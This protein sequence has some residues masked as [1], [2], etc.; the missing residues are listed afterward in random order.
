MPMRKS[1]LYALLIAVPPA[2]AT[3]S[4]A[5]LIGEDPLLGVVLGL[6]VGGILFSLML[7]GR[8]YGSRD[9]RSIG[10]L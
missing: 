4:G 2:F 1:V 8:E 9:D 10:E 7:L 3:G 6:V 5:F